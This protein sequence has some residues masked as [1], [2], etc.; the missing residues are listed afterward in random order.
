MLTRL[1]AGAALLALATPLVA[2][3]AAPTTPP[4]QPG[5]KEDPGTPRTPLP[6]DRGY[7][8]PQVRTE[9]INA[10][11][12]DDVAAANSTTTSGS[13]VSTA[14]V[15]ADLQAQYNADMASWLT[16]MNSRDAKIA[17]NA[18]QYDRQ[19]RAYADAMYVWR[20]Q[21]RDCERGFV[22]AC[23]RPTPNPADFYR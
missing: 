9:A 5:S 15:Q 19:Q 1:I 10:P 3:T 21:T 8:K 13:S 11:N 17:A 12:R 16:A 20:M 4:T 14:A 22:F 23:N 2:Q 18:S 6:A 7:D